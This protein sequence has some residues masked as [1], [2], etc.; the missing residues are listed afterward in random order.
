MDALLAF[1]RQGL[2][3]GITPELEQMALDNDIQ[4]LRANL[5]AIKERHSFDTA[6][7]T[8]PIPCLLYVGEDDGNYAGMKETS[9]KMP[10]ADFVSLPGLDHFT[11]I[12]RSDL[13][14]PHVRDETLFLQELGHGQL[15]LARRDVGHVVT[16][17]CGVAD[18]CQH[19]C[20][21][22]GHHGFTNLP[23]S[24]REARLSEP[25]GASTRGTT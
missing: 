6:L 7:S 22:I 17:E 10:S 16:R 12:S 19:V 5:Q 9:K 2:G 8:L 23:S 20:K 24:R 4:A 15:H 3:P 13:V 18:A 21:G 11:G 1:F 25:K 14:L